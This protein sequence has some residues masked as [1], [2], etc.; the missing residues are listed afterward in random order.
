[1]DLSKAYD[2]INHEILYRN[3]ECYGIINRT[4]SWF[5]S[6]FSGRK[7]YV[8]VDEFK[9]STLSVNTGLAQGSVISPMIFLLFINDLPRVSELLK[10]VMFA[11]DCNL[12]LSADSVHELQSNMNRELVCVENWLGTNKLILNIDKTVYMMF[13]RK[14]R[15]PNKDIVIKINNCKIKRVESCKFLGVHVDAKLSWSHH[16]RDVTTR[17]S[18]YVYIFGRIRKSVPSSIFVNV[19]YSLVY[20]I[21]SYCVTVWGTCPESI[22][23]KLI[24]THKKIIRAMSGVGKYEHT[25]PLFQSLNV[26]KMIDIRKYCTAIFV[27]RSL[28]G[29]NGANGLFKFSEANYVTRLSHDHPLKIPLMKTRNSQQSIEYQGVKIWN[30]LPHSVRSNESL[31]N[32]K[33]FLKVYLMNFI[34]SSD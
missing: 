27:F 24:V 5:K 4:L 30:S 25:G 19:Y 8:V 20:S 11:D 22:L 33:R 14:H 16:V 7:Q 31:N 12:F 10:F 29:L 34:Q 26:L 28:R 15:V 21:L 18:K 1:M 9:S 2:T 32:F 3:L 6:Y 23:H 17:L 13:Y